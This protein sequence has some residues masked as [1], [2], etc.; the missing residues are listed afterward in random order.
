MFDVLGEDAFEEGL[1]GAFCQ[2]L[3]FLGL[4]HSLSFESCLFSPNKRCDYVRI[5]GFWSVDQFKWT[6]YLSLLFFQF[7]YSLDCRSGRLYS[8]SRSTL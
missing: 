6:S 3:V 1:L 8:A 4:F 2:L 5:I 7:F